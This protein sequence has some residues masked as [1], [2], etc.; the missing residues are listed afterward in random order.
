[1]SE[2]KELKDNDLIVLS[3]LH[4]GEEGRVY[5]ILGRRGMLSRLAAMGLVPGTKI[6]VLRNSWGPVIILASNTRLAIGRGQATK[7][8]IAKDHVSPAEK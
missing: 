1:M 5:S 4:E 2:K 6:K 7:I 8:L 3:S